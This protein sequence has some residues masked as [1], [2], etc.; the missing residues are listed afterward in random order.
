MKSTVNWRQALQLLNQELVVALPTETVYGLAG[1]I[2]SKKALK[3]IFQ[4]KKRPLSHPLI[5]HCYNKK[6]ALSCLS[7]KEPLI[8]KLFDEFAPGPLT[9]VAKKHKAISPLITSGKSTVALRIPKHPI[10]RKV[11]K[12]LPVPIAMPSANPYGKI[13]P[14]SSSHVLSSFKNKIHVLEGGVCEKGLESTILKVQLSQ[15]K[16]LILRPGIITKMKLENFL[17]KQELNFKVEYKKDLFQPGGTD[18]HYKPPVPFYIIESNQTE[19]EI[20]QFLLKKFPKKTVK[21]LKLFPSSQKTAQQL[22]SQLRQLSQNKKNIIYT[23]KNSNQKS[24]L[25]T[26]IWNRL[27]KASSGYFKF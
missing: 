16:L 11:L 19:K 6:Q 13:S 2:D 4:I 8:E 25:W 5:V 10:I 15:K 26:A 20:Q 9:L 21:R 18:S 27:E 17:K 24:A 23:Q 22:Y 12:Q 1:R 3:K 14:V 7:Q